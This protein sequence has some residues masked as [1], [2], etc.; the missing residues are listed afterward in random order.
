MTE[1]EL[2]EIEAEL[3]DAEDP[4]TVDDADEEKDG[5]DEFYEDDPDEFYYDNPGAAIEAIKG[6]EKEIVRYKAVIRSLIAEIRRI[7]AGI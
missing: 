3:E 2:R 1:E 7:R 4:D 5:L 6:L